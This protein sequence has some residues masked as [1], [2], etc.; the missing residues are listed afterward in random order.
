LHIVNLYMVSIGDIGREH[1]NGYVKLIL[2]L[3]FI[4]KS[5]SIFVFF[6]LLEHVDCKLL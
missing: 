4:I 2:P 6:I 3:C 5:L 1:H